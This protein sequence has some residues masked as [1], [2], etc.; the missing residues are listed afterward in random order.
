MGARILAF[1]AVFLVAACASA[2]EPV[3]SIPHTS[4]FVS[5]SVPAYQ[6]RA[7]DRLK[8]VVFGQEAMSG[9]YTVTS[10]GF[11]DVSNVGLVQ[12]AGLTVDQLEQQLV[13]KLRNGHV[14]DAR[15][16]VLLDVDRPVFVT[17][18]VLSPGQFPF[19]PGLDA[20]SA[21]ALA[22]GYSAN[23]DTQSIFV[24]HAGTTAEKR[25]SLNQRPVINPGDVIRI[26][27]RG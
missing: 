7:N 13:E 26:P 5:N 14:E 10:E 12:A 4:S 27:D 22:G 21:V 18:A 3:T 24:T 23:A 8:L 6:L 25:Y 19:R 9:D 2:P 1:C 11:I 15:V 16:S 20:S 17:G